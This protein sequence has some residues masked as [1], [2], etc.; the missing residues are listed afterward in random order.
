MAELL[1]PFAGHLHQMDG[2]ISGKRVPSPATIV[3]QAGEAM[4]E[5]MMRTIFGERIAHRLSEA[6]GFGLAT[7]RFPSQL[8]PSMSLA[9]RVLSSSQRSVIPSM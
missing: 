5:F 1:R 2:D 6:L 7:I 4:L 3:T 9:R 8:S